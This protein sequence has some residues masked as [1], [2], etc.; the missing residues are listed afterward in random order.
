MSKRKENHLVTLVHA[1]SL[2]RVQLFAT[3]WTEALQAPL[4][5]GFSRQEQWGEFPFPS[6]GDL[7]DPGTEPVSP[8]LAGGFFTTEP[9]GNP[10]TRWEKINHV[11]FYPGVS[12]HLL[13]TQFQ[14]KQ[15]DNYHKDPYRESLLIFGGTCK[16]RTGM[17]EDLSEEY[18]LLVNRQYGDFRIRILKHFKR[19]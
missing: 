13:Y 4:P 16:Q 11:F 18:C 2:S 1:Q 12:K 8:A 10:V 15:I 17:R 7:P 6:L 9:P 19:A 14:S 3:S 5:M